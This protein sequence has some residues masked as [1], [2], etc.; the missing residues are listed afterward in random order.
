M[1]KTA[2]G[3]A[4]VL[5]FL[6]AA[7]LTLP[8]PANAAPR[9][10]VVP[11]D[12]PTI[13]AALGYALDGDTI[14]VRK[15]TYQEHSL[16]ISKS[17]TLKG[18]KTSAT[19]IDCIDPEVIDINMSG[20]FRSTTIQIAAD[21]ISILNLTLTGK[22]NIITGS[23]DET[24]I[25]GN[26]L[27]ALEGT[28]ISLYGSNQ[29]IV[30]N[31]VE[32]PNYGIECYGSNNNISANNITQAALGIILEGSYSIISG[33]AIANGLSV[34]G[35][36]NVVAYNNVTAGIYMGEGSS[37]NVYANIVSGGGMG[38]STGQG[39]SNVFADNYV[40]NCW[41][42]IESYGGE[43]SIFHNN[44]V[45]NTNQFV[46]GIHEEFVADYFDNGKEGNFWSDYAGVDAN[47]D[48]IGDSP[49]VIDDK[50]RDN[51]PLMFPWGP[52]DIP[53]PSPVNQSYSGS[54]PLV[55]VVD[56][57]ASWLGYSIDGKENVTVSGNTTIPGLAEGWHTVTVHANDTLGNAGSSETVSFQVV[58]QAG[59][60]VTL[61]AGVAVA[62]VVTAA[63]L[64]LYFRKRKRQAA[65]NVKD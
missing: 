48:G 54:V 13:A 2:L 12:A 29:T 22:G 32:T 14:L 53:L 42:G 1:R 9:T 30:Q 23:G 64:L 59:L 56:R 44:F 10:I 31:S 52:W 25:V 26:T 49:Y 4:L 16:V 6:A 8:F 7:C 51:F 45:N 19:V 35:E 46:A 47:N 63:G 5:V 36:K 41:T 20:V 38:L 11:D 61:L 27:K 43:N 40:E 39:G 28:G 55:F 18:E 50:R 60:S 15:G 33:N 62:I 58:S 65:T 34:S 21:R 37:N 17:I 57:P 3:I 24:R